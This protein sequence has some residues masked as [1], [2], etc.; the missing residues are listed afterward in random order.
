MEP[1]ELTPG[2]PVGGVVAKD[3]FAVGIQPQI[4]VTLREQWLRIGLALTDECV[5]GVAQELADCGFGFEVLLV[6]AVF[7]AVF[8]QVLRGRDRVRLVAGLDSVVLAHQSA[9]GRTKPR[10]ASSG[11]TAGSE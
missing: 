2:R 3:V 1:A 7:D 5:L 10:D 8:E 4:P 9:L 11:S 6:E